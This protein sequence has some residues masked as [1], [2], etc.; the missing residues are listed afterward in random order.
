MPRTYEVMVY[1]GVMPYSTK[2]KVKDFLVL[3]LLAICCIYLLY[4]LRDTLI[5]D[6]H[7]AVMSSHGK[8]NLLFHTHLI[9]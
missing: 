7:K 6:K 2:E 4:A 1:S 8:S 3:V 9:L 5:R